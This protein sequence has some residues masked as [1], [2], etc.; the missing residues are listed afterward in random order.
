MRYLL[1]LFPMIA[2]AGEEHDYHH[3]APRSTMNLSIDGNNTALSL[4]ASQV[5]FDW[6]TTR[7]QAGIGMGNYSSSTSLAVGV[8]KKFCQKCP[9]VNGTIGKSDGK[10]GTGIGLNFRF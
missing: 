1:L 10:T 9:L 2:Y 8:G 3:N 4:A 5:Q 6:A 7:W